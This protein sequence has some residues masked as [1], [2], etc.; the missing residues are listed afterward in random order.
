MNTV[1]LL[2][3]AELAFAG[4]GQFNESGRPPQPRE[5]TTLN[6]DTHGF[7]DLQSKRFGKL[8]EV[9]VS[10][11]EDATSPGGSGRT[12]FDTTVFRRLDGADKGKIF[13]SFR[14][15]AQQFDAP[16]PNDISAADEI[17]GFRAAASQI[18][19]M[20]NWWQRVSTVDRT[21]LPQYRIVHRLF[22]QTAPAGGV[23]LPDPVL[24]GPIES[25]GRD[26]LARI[27]AIARV[28]LH[29]CTTFWRFSFGGDSSHLSLRRAS[30][31]RWRIALVLT[32][33]KP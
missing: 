20:Y 26:Y 32:R 6:R 3:Y 17:L 33:S 18:V 14:G 16:L 27:T 29:R 22:G 9:A 25:L 7:S 30:A 2:D 23:Y 28:R 1:Q 13:I 10:T 15:T 5:L 12:S 24:P 11:F 19:A 8:F 31:R 4:Y 21:D